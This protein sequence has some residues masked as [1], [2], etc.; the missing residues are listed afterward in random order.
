M[1]SDR[2]RQFLPAVAEL[3]DRLT[4]DQIK[5]VLLPEIQP[6]VSEEMQKICSDIDLLIEERNLQLSARIIRIIIALAQMNVHIWKLKDYMQENPEKYDESLKLAHQL[7]GIR[8]QMKNILLEEVGDKEKS[9]ER[10]NY[11]TDGL[12]GWSISIK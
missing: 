7:N 12:K 2:K 11:N 10:T 5:E 8:N 6:E 3:I 4:V 1:E 9:A